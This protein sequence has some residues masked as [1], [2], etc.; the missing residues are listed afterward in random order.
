MKIKNLL[1]IVVACLLSF[2]AFVFAEGDTECSGRIT[3]MTLNENFKDAKLVISNL[4]EPDEPFEVITGEAYKHNYVSFELL[5]K[6]SE[7]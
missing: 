3:G 4:G 2:Q 1:F 7:N 5:K 6:I